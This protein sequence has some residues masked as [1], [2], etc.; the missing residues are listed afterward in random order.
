MCYLIQDFCETEIFFKKF[1][2]F[3]N[4]AIYLQTLT[5]TRIKENYEIKIFCRNYHYHHNI[6]T[7]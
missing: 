2:L 5:Q 1:L 3:L 4:N 7:F 6:R